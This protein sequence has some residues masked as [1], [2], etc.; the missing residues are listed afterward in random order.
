PYAQELTRALAAL[1]KNATLQHPMLTGV[2]SPQR[3]GILLV[4]S[5]RGL[6]GGYNANVI[7]AANDLATRLRGEGKEPV[8]YIIG[9]KGVAYYNFRRVS[10]SGSWIGFSEQPTFLDARDATETVVHAL[11]PTSSG[12]YDG[13]RGIDELYVVYTRFVNSVSQTPTVAQVSP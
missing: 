13:A 5:D 8:W 11:P 9:R 2:E 3:A 6:A 10:I 4:T 12:E 1:A 7:K